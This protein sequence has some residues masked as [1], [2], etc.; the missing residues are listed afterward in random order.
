[1]EEL[2][3][4]FFWFYM[5]RLILT[6][7]SKN[8]LMFNGSRMIRYFLLFRNVKR[9]RNVLIFIIKSKISSKCL[10][11]TMPAS[12]ALCNLLNFHKKITNGSRFTVNWS[13]LKYP[14]LKLQPIKITWNS[15]SS[16]LVI[17]TTI[18]IYVYMVGLGTEEPELN[19]VLLD[20]NSDRF[21]VITWDFKCPLWFTNWK[22][23]SFG[24][25]NQLLRKKQVN[26]LFDKKLVQN[27]NSFEVEKCQIYG[28][29]KDT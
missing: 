16:I 9:K 1:M 6:L 11:Q 3:D 15:K 19:L 21:C 27:L 17:S 14:F 22:C 8:L 23:L 13:K 10:F 26:L 20:F 24:K 18:G 7:K 29:V 2:T 28:H 25:W 4:V 12:M 5:F